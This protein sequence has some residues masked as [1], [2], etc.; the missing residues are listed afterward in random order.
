MLQALLLAVEPSWF[1]SYRDCFSAAYGFPRGL[2][3]PPRS[4]GLEK[5]AWA[6]RSGLVS[7]S[8]MFPPFA[9]HSLFLLEKP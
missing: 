5:A 6:S 7:S 1:S 3:P 8:G 2:D 4:V 9:P